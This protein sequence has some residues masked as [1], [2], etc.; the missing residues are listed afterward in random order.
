MTPD[1]RRL[2]AVWPFVRGQLHQDRWTTS[3]QP[4]D[5]HFRAWAEQEGLH[6]GAQIV[7]G[8]GRPRST[9]A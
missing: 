2:A 5:A 6:A 1:D 9:P 3:G 7:R 8:L 4:W